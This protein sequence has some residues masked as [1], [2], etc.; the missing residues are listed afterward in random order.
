MPHSDLLTVLGFSASSNQSHAHFAWLPVSGSLC[1]AIA[2][3]VKT[4]VT[5]FREFR[6]QDLCLG[7]ARTTPMN[8]LLANK[9]PQCPLL[10]LCYQTGCYT[11]M[12]ITCTPH[13]VT[14]VTTETHKNVL[15]PQG[16]PLCK[17]NCHVPHAMALIITWHW[18]DGLASHA[19]P[20]GFW[21]GRGCDDI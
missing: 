16:S 18:L 10:H 13:T 15:K 5:A 4:Y 17:L 14:C 1:D 7:Y 12:V 11:Y 21:P 8:V 6:L 2:M 20:C 19:V 3:C 9:Y